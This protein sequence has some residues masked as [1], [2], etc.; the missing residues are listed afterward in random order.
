M[1]NEK[2]LRISIEEMLTPETIE[3]IGVDASRDINTCLVRICSEVR[4][5]Q[6]QVRR[7]GEDPE[8]PPEFHTLDTLLD[9]VLG[10]AAPEFKK[11]IDGELKKS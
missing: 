1:V 8:N 6:D 10:D 2:E 9:E 3:R 4:R 7:L 11:Y 5:L